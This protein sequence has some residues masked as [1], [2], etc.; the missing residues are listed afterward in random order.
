MIYCLRWFTVDILISTFI[1]KYISIEFVRFNMSS[2]T[3]FS[4]K[5]PQC[6]FRLHWKFFP[7]FDS[8]SSGL[9]VYA[10]V[11]PFS[12]SL[13]RLLL[14]ITL[15]SVFY[16]AFKLVSYSFLFHFVLMYSVLDRFCALGC[17]ILS[18]F[19]IQL[20]TLHLKRNQLAIS[21]FA[22]FVFLN[23]TP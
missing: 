1:Y 4:I 20:Y 7:F 6:F 19:L 9:L 11:C 22:M 15:L 12:F 16:V 2:W 10:Y 8:T 14:S 13:I 3:S 17:I 23:L 18:V 5:N 21:L